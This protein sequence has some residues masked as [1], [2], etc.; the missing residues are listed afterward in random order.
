MNFPKTQPGY[1][2][3]FGR[4]LSAAISAKFPRNTIEDIWHHMIYE[5]VDNGRNGCFDHEVVLKHQSIAQEPLEI[6]KIGFDLWKKQKLIKRKI[7]FSG[8]CRQILSCSSS[9]VFDLQLKVSKV[10]IYTIF[11][12]LYWVNYILDIAWCL[13]L[14]RDRPKTCFVSTSGI[15]PLRAR[16]PPPSALSGHPSQK[17]S[18]HKPKFCAPTEPLLQERISPQGRNWYGIFL[19]L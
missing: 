1:P 5:K 11:V 8:T 10:V 15:W 18:N 3:N 19:F 7:T 4:S 2:G 17:V 12:V 14:I 13:M 9:S 6:L 16:P